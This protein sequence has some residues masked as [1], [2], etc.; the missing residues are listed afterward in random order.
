[1]TFWLGSKVKERL[2]R[3]NYEILNQI[4]KEERKVK[5]QETYENIV[6]HYKQLLDL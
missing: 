3:F 5:L 4:E 6:D 1:M 2:Y